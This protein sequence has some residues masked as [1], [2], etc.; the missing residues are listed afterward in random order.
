MTWLAV[1]EIHTAI[2]LS[3]NSAQWLYIDGYNKASVG[4]FVSRTGE[5][6]TYTN[7]QS[8]QPDIQSGV[9][10]CIN[11][12]TGNGLWSNILCDDHRPAVCEIEGGKFITPT[13]RLL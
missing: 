10:D 8:G 3:D 2:L 6:L 7:W 5:K 1:R 12:D 13:E 9:K 11:M 4:A